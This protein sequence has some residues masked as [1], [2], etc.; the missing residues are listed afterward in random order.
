M[1]HTLGDEQLADLARQIPRWAAE[2]GFRDV[3]I[4]ATELGEDESRLD[5]WLARG[6][7]AGM[8]YMIRHGRKRSRPGELL[9]GTLRVISVV[10][11][12]QPTDARP[13][14]K[15]LADPNQAFISR[16]ALGRDYHKV[17][18]GRLK[19]LARRIGAVCG[20]HGY[21]VFTDSA[22]VLEKAL[23]RNARLG[24]IGKNT[25]LLNRSAGSYCFLGEI[26]TDLALP[27]SAREPEK[28]LCGSCRACIDACPTG[29][30]RGP[31]QLDA[32]RCISYLTIENKGAIPEELRPAIGNRVFGCDDCQIV[33][34]WNRYARPAATED[35]QARH[36]LDA[37]DLCTL[38]LWT[39][40]EF[41]GKTEGMALRR[42][43]YT[44]WLR[45]LAVALGNAPS[46]LQVVAA[47]QAR[48]D[49]PSELVREHVAWALARHSA[50]RSE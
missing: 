17:L 33:C 3:G 38:F 24:W 19:H 39:E 29:A 11:D 47:L 10:M 20:G 14:G 49:H 18:R 12:Y 40:E 26:Y 13:A 28:D 23:A 45:N 27:V 36:G 1:E 31:Y 48:R 30:I 15:A 35:F 7:H 21:R 6:Y 37:A 8:A 42:A 50:G 5:A 34:P 43:G 41:L 2:L 32:R 9:P 22:P 46:T 4:A 16:Y 25:L 44:G